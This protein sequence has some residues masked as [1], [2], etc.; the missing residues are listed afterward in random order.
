MKQP[1]VAEKLYYSIGEVADVLGVNPS[2]IRY[3]EKEFSSLRPRKNRRGNRLFTQ[4]EIDML[5]YIYFLVKV[6][7]H[8]LDGAKKLIK[9][10]ENETAH[11]FQALQTLE[12]LKSF[13]VE[14]RNEL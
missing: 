13:L 3:W 2:L 9:E 7:G 1:P 12:K 11:K 14:L 8:T 6:Q 5:K 4:K 10:K